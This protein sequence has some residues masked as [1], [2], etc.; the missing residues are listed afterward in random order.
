MWHDII[1]VKYLKNKPVNEWINVY[2]KGS[3]KISNIWSCCL[4]SLNALFDL[5]ALKPER[6][7]K[8][9]IGED[10]IVGT[11]CFYKF[12]EGLIREINGKGITFLSW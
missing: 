4:N 5:V 7:S 1:K 2:K 12:S 3:K 8:I 11:T 9:R 10:P 6:D